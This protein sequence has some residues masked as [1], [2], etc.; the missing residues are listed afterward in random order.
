MVRHT[1]FAIAILVV[2]FVGIVAWKHFKP[3]LEYAAQAGVSDVGE[4]G[5]ISIA[6]DGW[7]GYFPFCSQELRRR[8]NRVGYGLNCTDDLADYDDRF[9]KLKQN[10]YDFVVATVDSYVLN[11]KKYGYPGPIISVIHHLLKSAA[12]HFDVP[13]FKN[14]KAFVEAQGSEDAYKKLKSGDVDIAVLWEPEVKRPIKS[15][16]RNPKT[17][18]LKPRRTC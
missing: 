1:K 17:F 12:S 13:L 7:V 16:F 10:Q 15:V 3:Q 9:K 11:G 5:T 6:V 18:S 4:K 8:L 14:R 2:G